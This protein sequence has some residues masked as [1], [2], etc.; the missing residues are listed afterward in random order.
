MNFKGREIVLG[1]SGGIAC[2]K[3]L[4]IVRGIREAGGQV[5]VVMT[6]AAMEF[7]TPLTFQTLSE[8]PVAT[9]LFSLREESKIGHIRIVENADA[10]IVAPATANTIGKAAHGIADD[11]LSTVL[12]ACDAPLIIA[13]AMNNKMWVHPAVQDNIAILKRRGVQIVPPAS[14]FLA[15]G[16]IGPGRMAEPSII[17]NKLAEIL[18]VPLPQNLQHPSEALRGIKVLV[19]AG[20]TREKID[21]VRY[22]TN[23]SS[24]KM[25]YALAHHCQTLGA[26][27][28]LI[29][30]P[31]S[32]N[33]PPGIRLI[34]VVSSEEMYH[35]VMQEAIDS[36]LIIKAAA[37][38]D[39]TVVSPRLQ[40]LKKT[41]KLALEL[42]KTKDI[43]KELGQKKNETQFLVGFAAESQDVE[44][45][46]KEKLVSKNLDLIV[47]NNILEKDAGFNVD[48][49]RVLLIDSSGVRA[50]PLLPKEKV[51]EE[52]VSSILAADRWRMIA[53]AIQ[54]YEQ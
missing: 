21:A 51:A 29:S 23:Y 16:T 40:K 5:S 39:Y 8:K 30:G 14:G 12:L 35:A 37:V 26:E 13:P 42:V 11:Y 10:V 44:T 32:L 7:V 49:N 47:A 4:E 45:Y 19:T 24:G 38:S 9:S 33:V 1:V 48:T 15:C 25:G 18:S 31:T 53:S 43:L 2:Y 3:A 34:K 22:L 28:T 17:L 41:E 20:P 27:V 46:A 6:K 50:L 36:K 52:I 54:K